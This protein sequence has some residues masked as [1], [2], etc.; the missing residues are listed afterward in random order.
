MA[1]ERRKQRTCEADSIDALHRGGQARSSG[2]VAVMAMERRRLG[3]L[4]TD[5]RS[6]VLQEEPLKVAKPFPVV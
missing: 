4:V 6:T 5:N 1:R 2:E 3:H